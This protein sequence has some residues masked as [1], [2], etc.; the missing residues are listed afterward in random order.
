M[1]GGSAAFAARSRLSDTIPAQ[2]GSDINARLGWTQPKPGDPYA[3][4]ANLAEPGAGAALYAATLRD[5]AYQRPGIVCVY[6]GYDV[7]SAPGLLGRHR[8]IVFQTTGYL[9]RSPAALLRREPDAVPPAEPAPSPLLLDATPASADLS[10]AGS[11]A[12]YC[13]AMVETV[14]AGLQQGSDVVVVTPPYVSA[15][16]EAQQRALAEVLTQGVQR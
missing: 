3:S 9:P 1:V 5:Y 12:G 13:A 10:C 11:S 8:S 2:L 15:R 16:H 14:R 6:D 7:E 4:V